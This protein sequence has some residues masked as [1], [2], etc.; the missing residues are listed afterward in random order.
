V[1][2]GEVYQ[3]RDANLRREV[4]I[5][6]LP[7]IFTSDPERLGRFERE[8][9]VL[10]SLNHPNIA[11]IH[12]VEHMDASTGSGQ[13]AIDALVLEV[14]EGETLAERLHAGARP[15]AR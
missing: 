4:A 3:A 11:T 13:A 6:V 5:K 2:A 7:T 10:A 9:R 8:A 12:G 15:P 14:V 1:K